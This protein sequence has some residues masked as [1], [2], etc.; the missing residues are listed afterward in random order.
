MATHSSVLAWRIQGTGEPGGLPSMGLHR[1]GHDWSDLAVA[2][3][4]GWLGDSQVFLGWLWSSLLVLVYAVLL[5]RVW[6][7]GKVGFPGG[8]SGKGPPTNGGDAQDAGSISGLGQSPGG[9]HGNTLQYSCLENVMDRGAWQA[10]VHRVTQSQTWLK[11]LSTHMENYQFC[12]FP[13]QVS[14]IKERKVLSGYWRRDG[15]LSS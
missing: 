12:P 5:I 7:N 4:V 6:P 9:R 13:P 3:A 1:V 10:I 8:A 11:Q 15:D 14:G 2:A